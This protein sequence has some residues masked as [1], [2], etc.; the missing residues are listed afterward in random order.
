VSGDD[1]L[2]PLGGLAQPLHDEFQSLW[3]QPVVDL[4]DTGERRGVGVIEQGEQPQ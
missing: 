3:V 4:L 2:R 1:E